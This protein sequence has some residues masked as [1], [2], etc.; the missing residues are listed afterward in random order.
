MKRSVLASVAAAR[1]AERM[2]ARFEHLRAMNGPQLASVL[3]GEP[4]ETYPWVKT[5]AIHGVAEAQLRLGGMLLDGRGVEQDRVAACRWFVRAARA[6][7]AEAMNMAG[8][9]HEH[10]WGVPASDR[11]AAYWYG[12]S[13]E[14]GHD[15]G[16]YNYAH[17][18]FDGR[19]GVRQDRAAAFALYR[20]AAERGH[21]RAMNLVARCLEAGWGVPAAPEAAADWY[22]RSA[23]A[24]Y[25]RAQFNH[26]AILA[27]RGEIGDAIA[28][29]DRARS[30][31]D[32]AMEHHVRSALAVLDAVLIAGVSSFPL[33]PAG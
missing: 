32:A 7:H 15:W 2:L 16:E 23:E 31:G 6:G 21:A 13:A 17:M 20:R 19:G 27:R 28:W 29:L 3:E 4:H 11:K 8:R 22:R 5:A 26:A 14:S 1:R 9:C 33:A 12:R 25:F 18:L 24:G 30:G 10:G